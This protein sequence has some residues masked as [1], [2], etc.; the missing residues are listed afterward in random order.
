LKLEQNIL[1]AAWVIRWFFS[2]VRME[3]EK[4]AHSWVHLDLGDRKT[5]EKGRERIFN[6][7]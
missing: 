1:A 2:A 7:P 5:G 3:N 4:S 6:V